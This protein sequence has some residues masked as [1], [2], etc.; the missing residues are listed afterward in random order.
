MSHQLLYGAYVI[1]TFQQ[2]CCKAMPECMRAYRLLYRGR[3]GG[4]ANRALHTGLM[5]MV[6]ADVA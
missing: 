3:T 5:Y 2:V 4:A 6:A 1:S